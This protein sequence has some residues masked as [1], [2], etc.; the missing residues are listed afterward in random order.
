MYLPCLL[1]YYLL[2]IFSLQI[3]AYLSGHEHALKYVEVKDVKGNKGFKQ[4][5]SGAA[6]KMENC[7]QEK[8]VISY[9]EEN[10]VSKAVKMAPEFKIW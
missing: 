4:I 8:H 1:L 7:L 3:S 5:V 6:T 9:Y 2:Q 10:G